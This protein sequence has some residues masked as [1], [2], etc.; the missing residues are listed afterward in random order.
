MSASEEW[1]V[2]IVESGRSGSIENRDT[3][4]RM[5][6]YWEFGAGDTVAII[7][8]GDLASWSSKHPWAIDH[9][10]TILERVA[11]EVIRHKAP[12]FRSEIDEKGGYIYIRDAS[13]NHGSQSIPFMSNLVSTKL[14]KQ[15]LRST[16]G[17]MIFATAL[18][19]SG[20]E[21]ENVAAD[22]TSQ[23]TPGS[24]KPL[25]AASLVGYDGKKLRKSVDGIKEANQKHNQEL[26]KAV[27][28]GPDQ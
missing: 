4:G 18:L 7:W 26:E 21:K 15:A 1:N 5:S 10:Q 9:R 16:L 19:S 11:H 8:V 25:E 12:K 17:M 23:S 3:A 20:C 27:G 22:P 13:A 14:M 2:K 28:S 6:F 24:T